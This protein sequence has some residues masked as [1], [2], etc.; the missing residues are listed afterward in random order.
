MPAGVFLLFSGGARAQISLLQNSGIFF[1]QTGDVSMHT[2]K[3]VYSYATAWVAAHPVATVNV[4]LA[5][6]VLKTIL[7]IV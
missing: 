1:P 3:S 6:V 7:I 2:V 5:A 4:I